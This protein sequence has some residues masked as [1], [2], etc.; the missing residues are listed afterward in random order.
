MEEKFEDTNGI[1]RVRS[2]RRT[3]NTNKS[4]KQYSEN[5]RSNNTNPIAQNRG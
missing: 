3:D 1:M 5:Y 2:R 4:T